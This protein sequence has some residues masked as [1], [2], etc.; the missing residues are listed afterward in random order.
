RRVVE[1]VPL[2]FQ[3]VRA[4]VRAGAFGGVVAEPGR[5]AADPDPHVPGPAIEDLA[6]LLAGPGAGR[7]VLLVEERP[8]RTPEVTQN[9]DHIDQDRDLLVAGRGERLDGLDLVVVPVDHREPRA[10]AGRIA[11]VASANASPITSAA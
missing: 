1:V 7:R 11:A 6:E 3:I 5:A 9:M 2:A 4:L 10:D 8:R